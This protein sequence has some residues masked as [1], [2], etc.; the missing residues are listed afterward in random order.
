MAELSLSEVWSNDKMYG[1]EN[2]KSYDCTASH[3]SNTTKISSLDYKYS[4]LEKRV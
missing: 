3:G 1:V 4:D 2:D